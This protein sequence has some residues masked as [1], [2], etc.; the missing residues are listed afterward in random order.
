MSILLLQINCKYIFAFC[1]A[2]DHI[3]FYRTSAH[4]GLCFRKKGLKMIERL[5]LQTFCHCLFLRIK[6][7]HFFVGANLSGFLVFFPNCYISK[8]AGREVCIPRGY[9]T[10]EWVDIFWW[11]VDFEIDWRGTMALVVQAWVRSRVCW[12]NHLYGF[13]LGW[14]LSQF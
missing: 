6:V 8:T 7:L 10:E 13:G 11:P 12:Y 9:L 14:P 3:C 2:Y 1:I 5:V 4:G